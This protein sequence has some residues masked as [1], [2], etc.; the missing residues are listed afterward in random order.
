[1][2]PE[3][4]ERRELS[5]EPVPAILVIELGQQRCSAQRVQTEQ[6]VLGSAGDRRPMSHAVAQF[7]AH[8]LLQI[9]FGCTWNVDHGPMRSIAVIGNGVRF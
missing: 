2:S 4:R 9:V 6:S 3:E 1:M 7:P 5:V 8:P